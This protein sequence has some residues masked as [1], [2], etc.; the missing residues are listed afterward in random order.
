[1]EYSKMTKA[2]LIERIIELEGELAGAVVWTIADIHGQAQKIGYVLSDQ[3]AG[4]ILERMIRK[5]DC[6]VG[7]TWETL[8]YYIEA[9]A[10]INGLTQTEPIENEDW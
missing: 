2:Q 4:V 7:I 3:Q 1:M 5:H 10:E 6:T 8:E 9:Y